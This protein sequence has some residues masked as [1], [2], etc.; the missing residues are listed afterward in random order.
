MQ[1]SSGPSDEDF[2]GIADLPAQE[3]AEHSLFSLP[4]SWMEG[5]HKKGP[6]RIR[7]SFK[8][9]ANT[10]FH[11]HSFNTY[12]S[13][14]CCVSGLSDESTAMNKIDKKSFHSGNLCLSEGRQ[15][16]KKIDNV[17]SLLNDNKCSQERENKWEERIWG[18]GGAI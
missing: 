16:I 11:V 18:W 17:C 1:E 7:Q 2:P 12:L 15:T 14:L 5:Q 10:T 13:S 9:T 4:R 8:P 6:G 3:R